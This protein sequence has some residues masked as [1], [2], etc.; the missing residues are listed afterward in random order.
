MAGS[1]REDKAVSGRA[2]NDQGAPVQLEGRLPRLVFLLELGASHG[3][4]GAVGGRTHRCGP[5]AILARTNLQVRLALVGCR[6]LEGV[7]AQ[8]LQLRLTLL[9]PEGFDRLHGKNLSY[10][11]AG[12]WRSAAPPVIILFLRPGAVPTPRSVRR[13]SW[14]SHRVTAS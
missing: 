7:L 9:E 1:S 3:E 10:S 11:G 5:A 14:A 2:S 6:H 4:V 12:R 13:Q 8:R